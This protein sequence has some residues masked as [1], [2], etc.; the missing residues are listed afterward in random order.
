MAQQFQVLRCCSCNIFQVQQIKKSKKWNCKMCDEKQSILRV[1]GQGSGADCRHHVQKLNLL[2]GEW[3]QTPVNKLRCKE[4]SVRI[5]D[6]NVAVNIKEKLGW[7]VR[8]YDLERASLKIKVQRIDNHELLNQ[9]Q[10]HLVMVSAKSCG[11]GICDSV[12]PVPKD[13]MLQRNNQQPESRLTGLSKWEKFLLSDKSCDTGATTNVTGGRQRTSVKTLVA[14]TSDERA[15]ASNAGCD[16]WHLE[17]QQNAVTSFHRAKEVSNSD[18]LAIARILGK[19]SK[20]SAALATCQ[21]KAQP[22]E[23]TTSTR[24]LATAKSSNLYGSLFSTGEDFD[25]D[26]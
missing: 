16:N 24:S 7:Q 2:Q 22:A 12:I 10:R 8:L 23:F 14:G 15:A 4:E 17:P 5:G 3:D 19:S 21:D 9:D 13:H 26:I 25:D 18:H 1:F 6:E 11:D 20:C